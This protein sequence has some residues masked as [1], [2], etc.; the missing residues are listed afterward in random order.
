[1]A[2]E[3]AAGGEPSAVAAVLP[4]AEVVSVVAAA[5]DLFCVLGN[6]VDGRIGNRGYWENFLLLLLLL[7]RRWWLIGRVFW[8]W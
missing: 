8:G 2:P 4:A 6:G 3:V 1:V 7:L 5:V